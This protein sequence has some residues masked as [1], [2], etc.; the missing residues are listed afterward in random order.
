MGER[1]VRLEAKRME[2]ISEPA[3]DQL[4]KS[5]LSRGED[6]A[7]QTRGVEDGH[8]AGRRKMMRVHDLEGPGGDAEFR[9]R[10]IRD[11][12]SLGI[13]REQ[14]RRTFATIV[15][16]NGKTLRKK[17]KQPRRLL[18][19]LD[20]VQREHGQHAVHCGRGVGPSSPFGAQ[21]SVFLVRM[22]R[23]G[24]ASLQGSVRRLRKSQPA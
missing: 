1:T 22:H 4:Q 9:K 21:L 23:A 17:T 8:Q 18:P 5:E 13:E 6:A 14:S 7:P 20:V 12:E 16:R 19:T 15:P 10:P 11:D 2:R 24:R 3:I